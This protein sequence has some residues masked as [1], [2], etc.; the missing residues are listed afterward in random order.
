MS[1]IYK[2]LSGV[3]MFVS[4]PL[5]IQYLGNDNYGVWVLI[6]TLF[7]LILLMD[8]GLAS[9][10]KTKI[11]ELNHIGDISRINGYIKS[12]YIYTIYIATALFFFAAATV[13]TLDLSSI[14]KIGLPAGFVSR[15]FTLNIFFFCINFVMNTH[16]A[17]FVSVHR[18]KYAEQSIAANQFF[19]LIALTVPL[20][21]YNDADVYSRLY[22]VTILNGV[23]CLVVNTFYTLYFFRTEPYVLGKAHET[24][25][26]F[27][28]DVF[29]L[30]LR[31]MAI[32]V[33]SLFLFSSDN[34]IL[35][36][37]FGP[38]EMVPYEIVNKY[39]QF[40][41]MILMAAMAPI[42]SM[43]TR[44]YLQKDSAWL[45]TSFRKFNL[46]YLLVLLGLAAAA[47]VA[48]PVMK[49]WIG[50]GFNAPIALVAIMA[51]F[52]AM[53]IFTTF[54]S[55]FFNGI[56]NLKSYLLLLFG[57]VALKLP[58]S[59]IFVKLNLG[60]LSVVLASIACLTIW[61]VVQPLQA[62]KIVGSLKHK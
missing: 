62:Y 49:I 50:N 42:W 24:D 51:I 4:I 61:C 23:V 56:G 30:G 17:L 39:F 38:S 1:A 48:A 8:F 52:T 53:R 58:L 36:Y 26:N 21:F 43:F 27:L 12:T 6:F 5:L 55:Y 29:Y 57:S 37:F 41:L 20:I 13:W 60:V 28:R 25:K 9:S 44:H 34:Y 19:F 45:L 10:L 22:I 32:Q 33:G 35:S 47:V 16:K 3:S 18:G 14:F 54:Y 15:I 7:Q 31:Y 59:Y 2:G 46:L 40:P 11:P